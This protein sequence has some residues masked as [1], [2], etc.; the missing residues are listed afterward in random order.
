M[1]IKKLHITKDK[2]DLISVL[3]PKLT[4]GGVK[5]DENSL[6]GGSYLYEDMALVLGFYDEHI[7]GTEGD[8]EGRRYSREREKYMGEL[9][10]WFKDN[11]NYILSLVLQ[12]S[13]KG[14]LKEG[15]YKCVDYLLNWQFVKEKTQPE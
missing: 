4:D 3:T 5:L 10:D 14:G 8:F 13:N 7:K 15:T 11:I 9:Y 2:L 1:A 6:W 12:Y